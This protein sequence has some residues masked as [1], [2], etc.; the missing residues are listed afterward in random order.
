MVDILESIA[1]CEEVR[2][3]PSWFRVDQSSRR[4]L[5]Q[6]VCSGYIP[7]AIHACNNSCRLGNETT[8]SI[9]RCVTYDNRSASVAA[10]LNKRFHLFDAQVV[11]S[12]VRRVNEAHQSGRTV[13]GGCC[14]KT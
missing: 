11:S 7:I 8:N 12:G 3:V 13:R 6:L 9:H 10:P 2:Y 14:R 4:Y 5:E 1:E